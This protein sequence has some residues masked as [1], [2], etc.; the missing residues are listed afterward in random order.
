MVLL[1]IIVDTPPGLDLTLGMIGRHHTMLNSL[2]LSS[3]LL[4]EK[5]PEAT[6]SEKMKLNNQ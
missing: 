6:E 1:G 2:V 4:K 3:I 5:H